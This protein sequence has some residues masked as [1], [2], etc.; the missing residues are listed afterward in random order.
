MP[1]ISNAT[2]SMVAAY[3][4]A[5]VGSALGL[6]C[7]VRSV[8]H[9]EGWRP[10]WLVLG[11]AVTGC[12]IWMMHI[13][14]LMGFS[15][16][17]AVITFDPDRV[18]LS[19]AV[20]VAVVAVGLFIVGYRGA[21]RVSLGVAGTVT[22]LGLAAVPYLGVG[23]MYVNG[24]VYYRPLLV[25]LSVLIA[26]A[27][28][29]AALW[30]AVSIRGFLSSL[31][32]GL[33]LAAAIAGMHYTALA[34]VGVHVRKNLLPGPGEPALSMMSMLI[35]PGIFLLLATVFIVLDPLLILG[36][37]EW[38]ER[39]DTGSAPAATPDTPALFDVRQPDSRR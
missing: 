35:G 20:A 13:I 17:G 5:F 32:A 24:T 7:V 2:V 15:V 29:T 39:T 8:H 18:L 4:A 1:E 12:G 3:L 34:S 19:L 6:R 38:D 27:A 37:G 26:V 9:R 28:A 21:G 33:F 10:G 11:A 14:V 36:E 25:V 22:G 31:G 30:S 16:P 23:A